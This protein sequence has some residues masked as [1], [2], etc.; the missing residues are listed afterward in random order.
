MATLVGLDRDRAFY[1]T[2]L[3]VVASYYVLFAAMGGSS[4]TVVV[5]CLIMSGFVVVAIMGFRG[6]LWLVVTGLFV[7]GIQDFF[8]GGIVRNPGVPA[9]WPG[10]CGGY[11]VAAAGILAWLLVRRLRREP[12]ATSSRETGG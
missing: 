12:G 7:H 2:V 6:S 8:H 5:E 11:D 9:W 1:P 3:M 10:F 4:R